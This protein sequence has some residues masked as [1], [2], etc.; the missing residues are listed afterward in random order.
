MIPKQLFPDNPDAWGVIYQVDE[1]E[2]S[3]F[4]KQKGVDKAD[5]KYERITVTATGK[6]GFT[7]HASTYSVLNTKRS[8][9]RVAPTAQYHN[10][11]YKGAREKHLPKSYIQ[12]LKQIEHNGSSFKRKS[13]GN[14]CD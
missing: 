13:V 2:R 10:C 9:D 1:S 12:W 4:D 7:Y 11:I 8:S 5:P 14:S 3:I 6:D